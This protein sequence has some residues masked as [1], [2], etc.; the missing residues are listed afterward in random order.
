VL[1]RDQRVD[2]VPAFGKRSG[3]AAR[4]SVVANVIPIS[5]LSFTLALRQPLDYCIQSNNVLPFA[6][7]LLRDAHDT[8]AGHSS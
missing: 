1:E 4:G 6:T 2:R 8:V 5:A 7:L 3:R